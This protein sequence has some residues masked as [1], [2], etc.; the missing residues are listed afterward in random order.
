LL[1]ELGITEPNEIDLEAIA[2]YRGARV[3]FRKLDGC[4]ARIIGCNDDAIIT[5]RQDCTCRRK[6]FSLAHEIGH[7]THHK[8]QTLVCRV[9]ESRP[10]DR[11]SPERVA[12]SYAA[13]LLMPRYLFD[14]TARAYPK[15]N[16]KTVTALAGIF[17]T[18]LTATAIRLVE[19]GHTAALLFCHS[20]AGRKWFTRSP[21]VPERW[22]PKDTLDA[23][24]FAFGV[25]YGG[26]VDDAMP[27][28]IG[29][30]AWFDRWEAADYEVHEQTVRTGDDEILTLL[31]IGD[32]RMLEDQDE[33]GGDR[34]RRR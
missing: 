9:E 2:F 24:S 27:R 21:D 5:I 34:T 4:E 28:K 19:G 10:Q 22:F 3:R 20:S 14:P 30:D 17:D 8:G 12:N 25:L 16:F 32:P 29:A 1:Q 26:N 13:D 18:S 33:R 23:D 15:L 11:M 31:L 7:W 6:R